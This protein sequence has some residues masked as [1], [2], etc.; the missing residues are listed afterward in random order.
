M[1]GI[2]AEANTGPVEI[3][4]RKAVHEGDELATPSRSEP[5]W[6]G[7]ISSEGIVLELGKKRTPTK[8]N[9]TCLEGV[10]T[11]LQQH[12]TVPISGSGKSQLIVPGT[13]D[14]YL[15]GH[16]NRVT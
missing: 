14:G 10:I 4:I 2:P 8:F 6:I 9:W 16:V 13:L 1:T 12:V 3:A 7:R 15:K 11:F 5:F